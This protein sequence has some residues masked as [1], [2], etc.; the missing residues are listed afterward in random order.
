MIGRSGIWFVCITIIVAGWFLYIPTAA[1]QRNSAVN[2]EQVNTADFPDVGIFVAATDANGNAVEGLNATNFSLQAGDQPIPITSVE[3]V[4]PDEVVV[5]LVLALDISGSLQDI[6]LEQLKQASVA[7]VN[8]LSPD[9][10]V[11]L[12]LFGN[13]SRV[14]NDLSLDHQA[15]INSID[16]ISLDSLEQYTALYNGTFL[17]V[18]RAAQAERGQRVVV[19]VTDGRNTTEDSIQ[20][21]SVDTVIREAQ[22]QRVPVYV[23]GVGSELDPQSLELLSTTG[24]SFLV[25]EVGGMEDIYQQLIRQ[26]KQQYRVNVDGRTLAGVTA[27]ELSLSVREPAQELDAQVPVRTNSLLPESPFITLTTTDVITVGQ[28]TDVQADIF[29]QGEVGSI[30]LVLNDEQIVNEPLTSSRWIYTWIPEATTTVGEAN[31]GVQIFDQADV[32]RGG[33]ALPVTILEA[34]SGFPWWVW[35]LVGLL[36]LSLIGGGILLATQRRGDETAYA[37]TDGGVFFPDHAPGYAAPAS[38]QYPTPVPSL[39]PTNTASP[40]PSV[41]IGKAPRM[42]VHPTEAANAPDPSL[43][44]LIVEKGKNAG[45][46]TPLYA[47]RE[48]TIGRDPTSTILLEDGKVSAHHARVRFLE[49]G[50]TIVD[51]NS[52]NGMLVNDRRVTQMRLQHGDR[53]E[54]GSTVLIYKDPRAS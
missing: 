4:A 13:D 23:A 21:V 25:G 9:D 29:W 3:R 49:N 39:P 53:I 6:G 28:A 30:D 33:V 10:Q 41:A 19:V 38:P 27:S 16:S 54:I 11:A 43:P 7:F 22:E 34:P 18:Q 12:V 36:A 31:L 50:F 1:Q 24:R 2:V 14:V 26:F 40:A 5:N 35:L 17:A 48:V 8:S 15:V 42:S 44:M 46:S 32:A 47:E 45:A 51:L 37:E 52:T 20:S